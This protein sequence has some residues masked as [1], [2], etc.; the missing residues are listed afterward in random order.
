MNSQ[1]RCCMWRAPVDS[2]VIQYVEFKISLWC[3]LSWNFCICRTMQCCQYAMLPVSP[4]A[5]SKFERG[6]TQI[7]L[8]A[9][10]NQTREL[11]KIIFICNS[12][13]FLMTTIF[14]FGIWAD[15]EDPY[16][17]LDGNY[18][19]AQLRVFAKM[20]ANGHIYR[21]R[22]PVH[23]SPSSQTALAESVSSYFYRDIVKLMWYS[24]P[25][26]KLVMLMTCW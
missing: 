11:M 13:N 25:N 22:K 19:A 21:G 2:G 5:Y 14:R 24:D 18:E 4:I 10:F 26:C 6:P 17:T 15:W 8:D 3:S 23:W 9:L 16:L 20:V 12:T 1:E 7:E